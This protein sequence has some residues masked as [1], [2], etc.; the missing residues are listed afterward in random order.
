[1]TWMLCVPAT[2]RRWIVYSP[3][4]GPALPTE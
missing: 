1:L 4:T 3:R 2:E